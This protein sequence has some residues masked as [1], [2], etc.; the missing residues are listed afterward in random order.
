MEQIN[1]F[2]NDAAPII[3]KITPDDIPRCVDC[4]LICSLQLNYKKGIPIIN[5]ECENNHKGN[6]TLND[7]MMKYNKFA[8]SKEKCGLCGKNQ[9]EIKGDFFYCAKCK[10]FLCYPCLGNHK[11]E[12][13]HVI[14]NYQKFDSLCKIHSNLYCFYCIECKMNL[15]A[16]CLIG[17]KNHNVINLSEFN[18]S[19]ESKKNLE[20]EIK[21]IQNIIN[22]LDIIKQKIITEI[23]NIKQ[24]SELEIK[25]IKILLYSYEYEENQNNL[26]YNVI[27]NLKN[28]E[29]KFKSNKINIYEKVYK[30]SGKYISFLKTLNNEQSNSFNNNFKILNDHIG[31]V[32]YLDKLN[33]GRL[34]SCSGDKSLN[35]YKKDSYDLQLSIKEH[36]E[37]IFSFIQLKNGKIITCSH[38]KTMKIIKLI[39]ENNYQIEQTL[40]GH[41]NRIYKIIE[42]KENELISVSFDKTMKVWK[43]NNENKFECINT[44]YFQ[45]S[46]SACDIFKL[47]E[48]EF[49]TS[50]ENDKCIKFWNS[51]NYS[52]I[53]TINKIDTWMGKIM[54]LLENDLLCV[55]G[56]KKGFYLIK[57]SNHQLIKNIFITQTIYCIK[58][59]LDGLFLCSFS[60]KG[61]HFLVKYKYEEQD[62]KKVFEKE[63]AHNN[64]I[65]ACVELDNGIIASGG[66]DN[67][68]K[69]W[70]N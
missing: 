25:F 68:I 27:Q 29:N 24:L 17:H 3:Y 9:K 4:N 43:L 50:S 53:T 59:C 34:I 70:K 20:E 18:F 52:N 33:D 7:Y 48:N 11:N 30:E 8:I 32:F 1:N 14:M 22:N 56:Y 55:G 45:K 16:Y 5:Y 57:I 2:S 35:I 61:N 12:N 38:D 60:E 31:T 44:I 23:N 19:Q 10:K 13:K 15:C 36:S 46:E 40:Q 65:R 41:S 67:L 51:N 62:L 54:C 58:K 63:K 49:V 47:N 28:F 42:I 69:L 64:F 26:N 6:I 37:G 21:N 39:G 66:E